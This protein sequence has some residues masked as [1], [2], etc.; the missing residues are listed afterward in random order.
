[1]DLHNDLPDASP[2]LKDSY[3]ALLAPLLLNSALAALK[4]GSASNAG[5]AVRATDR[6]L[7]LELNTADK[8]VWPSVRSVS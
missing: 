6:A 4:G 8:G 7:K 1:M 3:G 2:E 5:I